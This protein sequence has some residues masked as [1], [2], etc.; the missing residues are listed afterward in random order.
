MLEVTLLVSDNFKCAGFATVCIVCLK[1]LTDCSL[2]KCSSCKLVFYCSKEHQKSHWPEHKQLCKTVQL[3]IK[4]TGNV[5]LFDDYVDEGFSLWTSFRNSLIYVCEEIMKRKLSRNERS[6]FLNPFCCKVCHIH[7]PNRMLTCSNCCVVSYCSEDH[8]EKDKRKHSLICNNLKFGLDYDINCHTGFSTKVTI[9]DF[10][11]L[12]RNMK[13]FIDNFVKFNTETSKKEVYAGYFVS[14]SLTVPL[15]LISV[16]EKSMICHE[17]NTE[18]LTVHLIGSGTLENSAW[19]SWECVFHYFKKLKSLNLIFIGPESSSNFLP[20]FLS[21]SNCKNTKVINFSVESILYHEYIINEL[22]KPDIIISF[23]C[24]FHEFYNI[25][26]HDTWR[27]SMQSICRFANT[28]VAFTSY[29]ESEAAKDLKFFKMFSKVENLNFLV[30][31]AENPFKSLVP[32]H[33]W[34]SETESIFYNNA[35]ISILRV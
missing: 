5:G 6:L 23:N 1:R 16:I 11:Y 29:N 27:N 24:G 21:C 17:N 33:D 15:T 30:Q 7:R 32:F 25:S 18:M 3:M 9:N 28:V 10:E 19:W 35:Y 13:S 4:R 14:N 20:P 34:F 22:K 8:K 12:P 31:H 26:E 2:Q